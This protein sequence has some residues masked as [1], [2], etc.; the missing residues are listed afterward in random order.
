MIQTTKPAVINKIDNPTMTPTNGKDF[1]PSWLS[2]FSVVGAGVVSATFL[3][4]LVKS[5]PVIF[6]SE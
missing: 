3:S 4:S 1:F 6:Q 5:S 2:N